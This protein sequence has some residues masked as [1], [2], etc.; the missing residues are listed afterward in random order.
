VK[1]TIAK[2]PDAVLLAGRPAAIW[3]GATE[4]GVKVY[5]LVV[6]HEGAQVPSGTFESTGDVHRRS[7]LPARTWRTADDSARLHVANLAVDADVPADQLGEF[8]GLVEVQ[9]AE[10]DRLERAL[11]RSE[12]SRAE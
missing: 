3:A 8:A 4:R 9:P 6:A 11:L 12:A 2:T 10:R 1:I 5:A 7:G